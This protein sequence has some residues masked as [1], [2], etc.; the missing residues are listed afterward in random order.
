MSR[1]CKVPLGAS[2][3]FMLALQYTHSRKADF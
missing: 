3:T 2:A 1:G